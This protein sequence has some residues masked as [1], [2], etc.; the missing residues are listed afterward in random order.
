MDA[1]LRVKGEV[2]GATLFPNNDTKATVN[3]ANKLIVTI[4]INKYIHDKFNN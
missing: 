1:K 3:N 2:N 4:S